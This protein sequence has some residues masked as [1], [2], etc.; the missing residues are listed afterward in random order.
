MAANLILKIRLGPLVYLEVEGDNAKE[1]SEA[2]E[3]YETLNKRVDGLCSDLAD[4]VYPDGM[5]SEI[6]ADKEVK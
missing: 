4:R 3:G 2:L 5:D 1:I 6:S